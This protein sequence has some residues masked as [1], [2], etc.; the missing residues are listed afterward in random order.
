MFVWPISNPCGNAPVSHPLSLSRVTS[1]RPSVAGLRALITTRKGRKSIGAVVEKVSRREKTIRSARR[2]GTR[3]IVEAQLH[4]PLPA[5]ALAISA[6][7]SC[8]VRPSTT[9]RWGLTHLLVRYSL[10]ESVFVPGYV[11][12]SHLPDPITPRPQRS[13]VK[14]RRTREGKREQALTG[15]TPRAAREYQVRPAPCQSAR[16]GRLRNRARH[17]PPPQ[18]PSSPGCNVFWSCPVSKKPVLL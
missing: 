16:G 11:L 10:A 15:R 7:E 1:S 17:P 3:R 8:G 14:P 2:D 13:L 9:S 6:Q 18:P 12:L 4:T 5:S